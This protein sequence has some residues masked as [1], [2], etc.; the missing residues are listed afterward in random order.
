MALAGAMIA[1]GIA[2]A[3]GSLGSLGGEPTVVGTDNHEEAGLVKFAATGYDNCTVHFSMED[4]TGDQD[5]RWMLQYRVDQ[6]APNLTKGETGGA[7]PVVDTYRPAVTTVEG[8]PEA[9]KYQLAM[10]EVTIDLNDS[11]SVPSEMSS[12]GATTKVKDLAGVA[13]NADGKHTVTVD[14][15]GR[16]IVQEKISVEVTG[17]PT[18]S[19]FG[20]LDVLGSLGSIE[21]LFST[22]E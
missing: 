10:D 4:L 21:G 17:C 2:S 5:G 8:R 16:T 3:E 14:V 18:D 22:E 19:P 13:P 12:I 6:E 7:Y 9:A 20:S 15:Y 11:R 1:P